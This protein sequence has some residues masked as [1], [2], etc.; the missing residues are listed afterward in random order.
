MYSENR[1]NFGKTC[2]FLDPDEYQ[3]AIR[4]GDGLLTF[5]GAGD[6]RAELTTIRVGR[7]TLQRGREN[8]A[9]LSTTSIPANTVGILG[10][11]GYGPFPIVRGVQIRHGEWMCL[12]L[13]MQSHHRTAGPVEYVSLTLDPTDLAAAAIEL[14]GI[15]VTVTA[16]KVF[17]APEQLGTWL[18]SVTEAAAR[19]VVTTP[20]IFASPMAADALEQALLRP[21]IMCLIH[22]EEIK[23][24]SPFDRRAAVAKR[25]EEAVEANLDD[26]VTIPDLC[27]SIGVSERTLRILCQEQLG[28][29][30]IRFT[31]L[32]RL[33]L[34][35]RTLIRS[36]PHS[37]T[38]TEIA[39]DRGFWEMG[40]FAGI[41]KSLFGESPS[42]TLRRPPVA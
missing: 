26:S 27:R 15:P 24:G 6:F 17:R 23:P 22:G 34:V 31:M 39:T 14:T 35:R 25:F 10:W 21:M 38:V 8:V 42:A 4:G 1:S 37:A 7:L 18:L 2:T 9:R 3:S 28:V 13:G 16:G 30:P 41:Y 32:R 33:H 11:P 40:R 20:G 19:A 5:L 36:D 12:G 29:S